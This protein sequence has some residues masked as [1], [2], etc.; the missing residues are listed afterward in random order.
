APGRRDRLY[1]ESALRSAGARGAVE[2]TALACLSLARV[3]P[4][5]AELDQ[6]IDW[7]HAHRSG[8]GWIPH[9]AKGAAL[10]ALSLYHGGSKGAEDRYRLTIT[11]NDAKVSEITV[12][13]PAEGR[14]IDV[15]AKALKAVDANRVGFA[16][17]GRG[18]FS[19]AVVLSGF[20][21]DFVPDQD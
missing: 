1:W 15:P 20:T 2:T 10:A 12:A 5:A 6:A 17:E 16:F 13:G 11:V 18:T 14:T 9:K 8:P 4:Q 19:Y 7:L 21:R 3:R